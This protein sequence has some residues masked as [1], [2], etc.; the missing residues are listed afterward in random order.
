MTKKVLK[1]YRNICAEILELQVES[2]SRTLKDTV[3]GSCS[4]YPYIQHTVSIDGLPTSYA[5]RTL[6]LRL[7]V[8]KD[9]KE[10]IERFINDIED[11]MTRRVFYYRYV[12]G[13]VRMSW[14][15]VALAMGG[16]NTADGVRKLH[17][18]YLKKCNKI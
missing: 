10:M 4:G 8:L 18:R 14:T 13:K 16:G 6:L 17:D 2:N 12:I 15:S 9:K 3:R 5:N 11:S 7:R 1:Q